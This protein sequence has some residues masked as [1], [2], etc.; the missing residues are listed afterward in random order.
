MAD[1]LEKINKAETMFVDAKNLISHT[2]RFIRISKQNMMARDQ[3]EPV[4]WV[5]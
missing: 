4:K 1:G 5:S 2:L 3:K